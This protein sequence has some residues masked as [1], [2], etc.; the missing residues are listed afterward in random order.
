M[1]TKGMKLAALLAAGTKRKLYD[2][3]DALQKSERRFSHG[4]A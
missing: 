3:R 1:K 4:K 2:L